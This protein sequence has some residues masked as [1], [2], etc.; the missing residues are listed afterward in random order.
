MKRGEPA[1]SVIVP[2][3]DRRTL[4]ERKLRALEG[5][6]APFEVVVVADACTDDTE[7][8]LA[9]YQPGYPLSWA[10]APGRHAAYARNQGARMAR[11][12]VLLFSDDDMISRPGW[13]AKNLALHEVPGRVGISRQVLPPH[14]KRGATLSHVAGWW[15]AV[16]GS[17]SLH[18]DLFHD[19]GGYDDAFS[20]Y[21]GEDA[22]LGYRLK[23]AG[24][25]F[26]FLP[27]AVVEHWD[28][29]YEEGLAAKARSAGA[30]NV[31]VWRKHGAPEVAWALGVHPVLLGAKRI[32]FSPPLRPIWGEERYRYEV[33]YAEGAREALVEGTAPER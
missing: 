6:E 9:R 29:G 28:H 22:D 19:V 8:F 3:H 4:L 30:A 17:L 25:R 23:L 7:R 26:K 5:E 13:L 27:D 32:L 14:L 2:T 24:A 11:G 1:I 18:A 16:G 10:T 20:E 15:N 33:A 12:D 21:G 31:R